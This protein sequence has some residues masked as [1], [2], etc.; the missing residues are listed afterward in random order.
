[1]AFPDNATIVQVEGTDEFY[2]RVD[3]GGVSFFFKPDEQNINSLIKNL[4]SEDPAQIKKSTD[5]P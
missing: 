4:G 2:I 1:M 3:K 5:D